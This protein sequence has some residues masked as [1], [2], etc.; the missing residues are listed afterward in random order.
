[1]DDSR[2]IAEFIYRNAGRITDLTVTLDTHFAYQIFFP[3]FFVDEH[4][5]ALAPHTMVRLDGDALV[6]V[7][8]AGNLLHRPVRPNPAVAGWLCGGDYT[9]LCRQVAFYC[10]E[11]AGSGRYTLYLWPPHC[12]LGSEGHG[13]VG[14]IHEARMFH[15][16][17]RGAQ[18]W[19]EIKGNHPL[20]ENYSVL[21]PEVL[22]GWDGR[23]LVAKNTAFLEVLLK[24][25]A[26]VVAGQAASH[27]VKSTLDDLL[28]E[29]LA[30]NPDLA[31]KVYLLTDGMSSVVVPD[32]KGGIAADFTPQAEAAQQRFAEAGMRLVRST[33]PIESWPGIEM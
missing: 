23:P 11:L 20:T 22:M 2:R 14:T 12:L 1:M 18:S 32:G 26:V 9:W 15:A 30:Q 28:G 10:A 31:Q 19:A 5:R 3:W 8:P 33:D 17:L 25:D 21:G 27:C 24:A 13:L 16:F 6:N 7:D 29:V 4:D